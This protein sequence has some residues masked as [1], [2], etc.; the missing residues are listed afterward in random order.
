MRLYLDSRDLIDVVARGRPV[1]PNE[2]RDTLNARNTTLVY[3]WST[4][5]ETVNVGDLRESRS[6]LEILDELP[7]RFIMGLPVLIRA[8][9]RAA[10]LA[11]RSGNLE[12][13]TVDPWE[14]TLHR[15]IRDRGHIE[16][17][18]LLVN[19]SLVDH[20]LPLLYFNPSVCRNR[21]EVQSSFMADVT[22]DRRHD[23]STRQSRRWFSAGVIKILTR[24]G[25]H[26]TDNDLA[27]FTDWLAQN[28][29]ACPGWRMFS[30][31][32]KEF[33]DNT[34]DRGGRGDIP[35][36]SHITGVPYLDAI[37]LDKRMA[38]YCRRAGR[39][40][41]DHFPNSRCFPGARIF[42]DLSAW[43]NTPDAEL[44]GLT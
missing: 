21:E 22:L 39:R 24:C 15:A 31:T 16:L 9:F 44:T 33:C 18:D 17:V 34:T 4:V 37:T 3:S 8:E 32:Y 10:L 28:G 2:L 20:V 7:R 30:G 25:I 13:A 12:L 42:R 5:M 41:S 43:L 36:F 23:R 11:F 26:L 38:D 14:N 29:S 27:T 35:D 1:L 6:R 19:F 40:L